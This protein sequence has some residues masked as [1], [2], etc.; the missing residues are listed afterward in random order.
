M[1]RRAWW[2]GVRVVGVWGVLGLAACGE[3][4]GSVE[5]EQAGELGVDMS[6]VDMGGAD[7][8]MAEADQGADQRVCEGITDEAACL[9]AGCYGFAQ[10]GLIQRGE[11]EV[12]TLTLTSRCIGAY[13]AQSVMGAYVRADDTSQGAL[14]NSR[15]A[16]PVWGDPSGWVTC[17]QAGEAE[18]ACSCVSA[19]RGRFTGTRESGTCE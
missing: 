7:P 17:E 11:G 1:M 15:Y 12:C 19:C 8:D 3:S 16:G 10:V 6:V 4:G 18:G 5:A 13:G 14:T 2:R 9:S